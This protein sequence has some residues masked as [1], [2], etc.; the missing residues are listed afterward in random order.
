MSWPSAIGVRS[1]SIGAPAAIVEASGF[2]WETNGHA[3]NTVPTAAA[4]PVA[5]KRKSRRVGSA[6]DAVVTIPNPFS[7]AAG[8]TAPGNAQTNRRRLPAPA[9]PAAA[10][11]PLVPANRA[12]QAVQNR[13]IGTL[14]GRAQARY[15]LTCVQC[16]NSAPS[17]DLFQTFHGDPWDHHR[18]QIALFQPDI[19]QNAGTILRLCACLNVEAHIIEPAGFPV[20]DRHFPRAG[21]DYLDQV[22]I[23]RH[24]SWSKFEQWRNDKRY[25]L[26]LFT[27]RTTHC[28]LDYRYGAAE[29]LLF[30]RESAGVP[31][32]VV[33]AADARL[34]IPIQPGLRSLNV[35]VMAAMALGEALRQTRSATKE[36]MR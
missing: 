35:A 31:D 28:Y 29:I 33:T 14:A 4:A 27:T 34:V 9:T 19:P 18:M 11:R 26:V 13:S 1:T 24:D 22:T 32:E 12:E 25:R 17:D 7:A 2:I 23:T 3:V 36:T 10:E 15:R 30:G 6:E 5:T 8:G 21:M 16:T 20:S